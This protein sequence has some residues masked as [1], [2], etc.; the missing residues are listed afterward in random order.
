M[1]S[2]SR[3][4]S[5]SAGVGGR[6]R[7]VVR[8]F[9]AD[10]ASAGGAAAAGA[11]APAPGRGRQGPPPLGPNGTRDPFPNPIPAEEGAIKVNFVEF[12]ALPD[13]EGN[14]ARPM[15]MSYEPGTRRLFVNDMHG[16][17]Y[18]VEPRRQVGDAVSRSS[19]S[20]MESAGAVPELRAWIPDASRFIRSSISAARAATERST[21]TPIPAIRS[22]RTGLGAA[23]RTQ[24]APCRASRVDREKSRPR[25]LMMATRRAS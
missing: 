25:P 2:S 9:R 14:T 16:A 11:S 22:R 21:P 17:L 19:R 18:S 3:D 15:L 4:E 1:R 5:C 24:V 23:W 8:E 20:A 6:V 10:A 7:R 12:A 13:V